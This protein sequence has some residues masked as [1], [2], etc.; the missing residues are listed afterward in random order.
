MNYS[1][2]VYAIY[3]YFNLNSLYVSTTQYDFKFAANSFRGQKYSIVKCTVFTLI[4]TDMFN[5]MFVFICI[6][7]LTISVV[8]AYKNVVNLLS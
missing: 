4:N 5:S 7:L 6:L 2:S 8:G 3:F 1:N